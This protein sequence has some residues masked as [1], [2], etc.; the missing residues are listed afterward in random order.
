[1]L[2]VELL[3]GFLI[4]R[5]AELSSQLPP[6]WPEADESARL[7]IG[8]GLQASAAA[9]ERQRDGTAPATRI[10]ASAELASPSTAAWSETQSSECRIL[11][12]GDARWMIDESVK[13]GCSARTSATCG[14]SAPWL[15]RLAEW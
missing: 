13:L 14:H 3:I 4:G 12:S 10:A 9:L 5:N 11:S 7:P 15:Q 2:L 8:D 6:G 1:M